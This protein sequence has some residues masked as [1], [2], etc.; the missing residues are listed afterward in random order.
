LCACGEAL[1]QPVDL[2]TQNPA[3][4]NGSVATSYSVTYYVSRADAESGTNAIGNPNS[5]SPT[6]NP[7][8]IFA[9]MNQVYIN[10]CPDIVSFNVIEA[11]V[12]VLTVDQQQYL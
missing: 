10:R 12:P 9:K 2:T 5:F 3:I 8:Q 1:N 11:N 7:Q 6:V 4:L